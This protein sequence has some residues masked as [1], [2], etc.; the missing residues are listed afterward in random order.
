MNWH[1]KRLNYDAWNKTF[2]NFC[3]CFKIANG[4]VDIIEPYSFFTFSTD[5]MTIGHKLLE[6]TVRVDASKFSFANQV[7]TAWNNFPA[8][9]VNSLN[10][11]IL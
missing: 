4:D 9:V 8:M 1:S 10:V 6:Q 5:C 3:L 2:L 11:N 7:F